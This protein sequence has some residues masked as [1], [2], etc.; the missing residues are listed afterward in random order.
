MSFSAV[1]MYLILPMPLIFFLGS[2]SPSMMSND[3]DT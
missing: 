2:N 3:G 1:L